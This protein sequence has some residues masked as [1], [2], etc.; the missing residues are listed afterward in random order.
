MTESIGFIPADTTKREMDVL[1]F[2]CLLLVVSLSGCAS[3][4]V[5][6]DYDAN[7]DFSGLHTYDWLPAPE[8]ASGDPKVQYDGL[9]EKRVKAAVEEQLAQK[10]F[11]RNE[12]TP[13]FLVT[14]HA[15]IDDKVS[16][17]YLNDLYGYGPSWSSGYHYRRH[18]GGY[19][20]P[21]REVL[22]SEYQLGTLIIDIVRAD[23]KQLI[24]RGSASDEVRPE[25][26]PEIREKRVGEAVQKIMEQFPPPKR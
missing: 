2:C 26:S 24:W 7:A 15:A 20:A 8:L 17:T 18:V 5:S 21:G 12:K 13:D 19:T 22:V 6:W 14:Y 1:R 25:D 4:Q 10:K 9:L 11:E 16:V 23:S 3:M